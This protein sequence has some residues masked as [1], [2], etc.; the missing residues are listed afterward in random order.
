MATFAFYRFKLN[1][2]SC[3]KETFAAFEPEKR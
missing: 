2:P 1:D 3:T